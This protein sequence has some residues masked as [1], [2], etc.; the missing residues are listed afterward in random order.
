M[1]EDSYSIEFHHE[2]LDKKDTKNDLEEI[3]RKFVPE[4]SIT[5]SESS[6]DYIGKKATY[7]AGFFEI[8][9]H[10]INNM[11]QK[12]ENAGATKIIAKTW[13]D[14][15]GEEVFFTRMEEKLLEFESKK[16]LISY[17]EEQKREVPTLILN[18]G[19]D[20]NINILLFRLHIKGLS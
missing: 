6:I 20:S 18:Y 10:S 4:E 2:S 14:C 16:E 12:L 9:P 19:R 11:I 8:E 13:H 1:S 17:I 3:Y 15:L 5:G 7:Y